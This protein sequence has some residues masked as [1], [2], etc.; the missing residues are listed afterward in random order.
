MFCYIE[1]RKKN[2]P[3]DCEYVADNDFLEDQSTLSLDDMML[4][5]GSITSFRT[6]IR[7]KILEIGLEHDLPGRYVQERSKIVL[8]D[9]FGFFLSKT[10]E[11]NLYRQD[12]NYEYLLLDGQLHEIPVGLP[13]PIS[14]DI[15]ECEQRYISPIFYGMPMIVSH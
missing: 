4:V 2:Y 5:P 12:G 8:D 7:E 11:M 3:I 15:N 13:V 6:A 14:G 9:D 10:V 1:F